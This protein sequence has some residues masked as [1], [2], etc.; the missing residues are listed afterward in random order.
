MK[1]LERV[2]EIKG[3]KY[4]FRVETSDNHHDYDKYEELRNR[5]WD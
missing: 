3:N 4:L 5:V 2:H 1:G